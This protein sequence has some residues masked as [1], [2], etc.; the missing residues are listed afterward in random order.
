MNQEETL[1][2]YL[3]RTYKTILQCSEYVQIAGDMLVEAIDIED[4]I[5]LSLKEGEKNE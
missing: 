1:I 2:S 4:S 5:R 3:N